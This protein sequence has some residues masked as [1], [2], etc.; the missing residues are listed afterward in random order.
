MQPQRATQR[1]TWSPWKADGVSGRRGL[2]P[3]CR[4]LAPA[5]AQRHGVAARTH[6]VTRIVLIPSAVPGCATAPE[7][8][9]GSNGGGVRQRRPSALRARITLQVHGD[10][11]DKNS[12]RSFMD[13]V[14]D[15]LSSANPAIV[16]WDEPG[17]MFFV[18]DV[19]RY[20]GWA[21]SGRAPGRGACGGAM[22]TPRCGVRHLRSRR[23][24]GG[25]ALPLAPAATTSLH[26]SFCVAPG[27][28]TGGVAT[29]NMCRY[30]HAAC[31]GACR[32]STEVL[33]NYL[34]TSNF[35]SFVRQL[36]YY[37]TRPQW[38]R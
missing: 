6:A 26:D 5:V 32:F 3:R 36:N 35:S 9:A 29:H 4:F 23:A 20:V 7:H 13:K 8:V 24:V 1:V 25:G 17:T 31:P 18:Y 10:M 22:L 11:T 19:T 15:M 37:G 14:V 28:G 27:R 16:A 21:L 2:L 38:L 30:P 33:G 12:K 34:R